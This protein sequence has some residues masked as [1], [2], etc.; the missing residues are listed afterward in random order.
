[1]HLIKN[2]ATD[3]AAATSTISTLWQCLQISWKL[4]EFL[5]SYTYSNSSSFYMSTFWTGSKPFGHGKNKNL[6]PKS[7]KSLGPVQNI[8]FY[9]LQIFFSPFWK[10]GHN[11]CATTYSIMCIIAKNPCDPMRKKILTFHAKWQPFLHKLTYHEYDL[12]IKGQPSASC[13]LKWANLSLA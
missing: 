12:S 11:I 5:I 9:I 4:F 8:F 1:M 7:Q 3:T 13:I 2:N 6:V 10:T